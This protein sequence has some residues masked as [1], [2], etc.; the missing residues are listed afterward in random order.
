MCT[1]VCEM[2]LCQFFNEKRASFEGWGSAASFDPFDWLSLVLGNF[3]KGD[4]K[5]LKSDCQ[6]L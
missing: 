3:N 2:A 5:I 4:T 6:P 1:L